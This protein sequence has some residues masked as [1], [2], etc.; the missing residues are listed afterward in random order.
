MIVRLDRYDQVEARLDSARRRLLSEIEGVDGERWTK[1]PSRGWCVGQA[2]EHLARVEAAV[3]AGS[4]RAMEKGVS[5]KS[6][7]LDPLFRLLFKLGVADLVR[8]R[9]ANALDPADPPARADVLARL[10]G[11]RAALLAVLEDART[12]DVSRLKLAHPIFGAIP[13]LDMID[14]VSWHEERHR[15]QI[16]RIKS[17]ID[18]R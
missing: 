6:G 14:F 3:A 17:E 11:S 18:A 13:F 15:R 9:T 12:R 7:P 4:R 2:V 8:V 1:R 16:V 10:D 5:A